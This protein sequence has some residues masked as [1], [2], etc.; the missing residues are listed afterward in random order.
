[1][2]VLAGQTITV[3]VQLEQTAVEIQEITVVTQTQPLV[4][5]RRGH[6]R[7]S[8]STA[9]S[10]KNLP[11]DRLN[12]VLAL[13]PGVVARPHHQLALD[14]RR[15]RPTRTP[16]T[17]TAC[18]SRPGYR[19]T[20]QGALPADQPRRRDPDRGQRRRVRSRPRSPP[21]PL[22][23]VRQRPVRASSRSP[24]GPAATSTTGRCPTRTTSRSA[25]TTA[26]GSTGSPAASAV[27]SSAGPDLLPVGD[28][29]GPAV[30]RDRS[31][32]PDSSRSSLQ[33]GI[34]T[35]VTGAQRA[36]TI[37]RPT[38]RWCRSTTSRW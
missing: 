21:A 1:M 22:G 6:L 24:P 31:G 11:V 16:P 25:A 5:A 33:A 15:P 29:R 38:P 7:S 36:R 30:G 28:P 9:S 8:G 13:Q 26:S 4:P 27:R 18:R 32:R 14:P 20:S 35:T 3:D 17:S 19:G 37:R 2:K 12:Q 23:R 34:D 10:P